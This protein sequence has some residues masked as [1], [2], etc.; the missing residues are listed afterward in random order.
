MIAMQHIN[1]LIIEDYYDAKWAEERMNHSNG[2][3]ISMNDMAEKFNISEKDVE[4]IP[5]VEIN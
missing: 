2:Q 4:S 1:D 5:D 3:V